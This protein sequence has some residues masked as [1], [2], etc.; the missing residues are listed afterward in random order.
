L[1]FSLLSEHG[2]QPIFFDDFEINNTNYR[3][4]RFVCYESTAWGEKLNV[5]VPVGKKNFVYDY[6]L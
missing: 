2:S 5:K 1:R 3:L 4:L 6:L